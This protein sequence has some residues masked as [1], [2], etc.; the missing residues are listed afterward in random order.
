MK[1]FGFVLITFLLAS[2]ASM[3]QPSGPRSQMDPET[4]AKRQTE[5][6]KEIVG[7]D[8]KQEKAV[9]DLSLETSKKMSA[10]REKTRGDSDGMRKQFHEFR[11][12]QDKKM[13][14]IMTAEQWK[15]YEKH[16]EEN[17]FRREPRSGRSGG[18]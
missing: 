1:K 8:A 9:Y 7:L 18:R 2:V 13:K 16:M 3:A 5:R 4:M 11:A 17:R 10:A 6:V 12:E 15:K 14:E